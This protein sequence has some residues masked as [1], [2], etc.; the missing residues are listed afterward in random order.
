MQVERF[1]STCSTVVSTVVLLATFSL[2][3]CQQSQPPVATSTPPD[4]K[5]ATTEIFVTFEGP[6]AIV[7][8]PKNAGSVIA[9]APKTKSHAPLAVVPAN[10]H[11]DAGIY[12]L[13]IPASG[14]VSSPAI[15]K[16]IVQAHIDAEAVQRAL[17]KK[18]LYA[19]RLPK[20]ASY[21][22][23]TRSVSR[24]GKT[25]PPDT[26]TEQDYASAIALRYNVSNSA[27]FQLAGAQDTGGA[28]KPVLLE[29]NTRVVRFTIDPIQVPLSDEPCHTHAREAFHDLTRLMGL[30]LYVDFPE[31]P[32]DCRKKDPQTGRSEKAQ[33]LL[34]LPMKSTAGFSVEDPSTPQQANISGGFALLQ[35]ALRNVKR[36]LHAAFYF[37]HAEG[38]ACMAPIILGV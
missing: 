28:I 24:V 35:F 8:D 3:A 15:D 12:D 5:P 29:L 34:G 33:S 4:S 9:I 17:D 2:V 14:G 13:A 31:S 30:T 37:F 27:G 6:W 19:V 32:A 25:Y 21:V 20:P 16:S 22:A 1:S 11:L 10:M 23:E 7:A 18:G 36:G 38:G 26:S